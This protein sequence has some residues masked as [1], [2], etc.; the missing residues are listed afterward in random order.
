MGVSRVG[1]LRGMESS[2]PEG[3]IAAINSKAQKKEIPV[4]AEFLMVG[5]SGHACMFGRLDDGRYVLFDSEGI[6]GDRRASCIYELDPT[7]VP[8]AIQQRY[9]G[10][11][12]HHRVS[13]PRLT[14]GFATV[15]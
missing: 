15:G 14:P 12:A 2:F 5:G 10:Y 1:I 6:G 7:D 3:L 11:S 13:A 4:E 9:G 8:E